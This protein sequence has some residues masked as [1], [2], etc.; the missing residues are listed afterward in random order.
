MGN[1]ADGLKSDFKSETITGTARVKNTFGSDAGVVRSPF[2]IAHWERQGHV[3]RS[4]SAG[5]ESE[6]PARLSRRMPCPA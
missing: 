4:G 1:G 2:L 3:E 6:R 5:G